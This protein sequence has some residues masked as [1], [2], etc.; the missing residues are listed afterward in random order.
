MSPDK[1]RA[2]LITNPHSGRGGIDLSPVL[3]VLAANGWDAT[4]R[5]VSDG[6]SAGDLARWAVEQR[7]DVIVSC[8]GDGTLQQVVAGVLGSDIAIGVLPGGTGNLWTHEVGIAQRLDHAALQLVGGQRRGVDVGRIT[9]NGRSAHFLLMAGLGFDGAVMA[10]VSRRLENRLG[11]AAIVA[12]A[13]AA[14][15]HARTFPVAVDMD[16]VRWQGDVY[17]LL[18]GNTRVY[19]GFARLTPNAYVDDGRLDVCIL[20]AQGAVALGRELGSLLLR[21]RPSRGSAITDRVTRVTI[22]S[23]GPLPLALDGSPL[24]HEHEDGSNGETIYDCSVVAQGVTMLLPRAYDGALFATGAVARPPFLPSGTVQ[25][26]TAPPSGEDGGDILRVLAVAVDRLSA[27]RPQDGRGVTVAV[28]NATI[29]EDAS[30]ARQPLA[31]FLDHVG[32]G[33]LV[34]VAGAP[35]GH[36]GGTIL[37]R[38]IQ[39]VAP[40]SGKD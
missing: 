31:A 22:Q 29:A 25:E 21:G 38:R 3:P 35:M 8:G 11:H 14:L 19:R 27:V 34:R 40:S 32:E 17:E 4:V 7:F 20:P 12:A 30:G 10:G 2:C 36:A 5:E 37:A 26:A 16:G 39:L 9:L 1:V 28:D 18:V 6:A 24:R 23:A 33:A 13:L 15:P